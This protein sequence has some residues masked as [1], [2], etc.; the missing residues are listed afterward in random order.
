MRGIQIASVAA[1]A[2]ANA[3]TAMPSYHA[4]PPM[5]Q[6]PSP[7]T[8]PDGFPSPI[9][10]QLNNINRKAGGKLSD[11]PPPAK[12]ANGTLDIFQAIAFGETFEVAFFSSLLNNVTHMKDTESV[13]VWRKEQLINILTTVIA[14]SGRRD[15][16]PTP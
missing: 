8:F 12:L 6:S 7:Q 4:K 3:A 16:S 13:G 5:H 2:L 14:V 9:N 15:D 11:A 1:A 10:M